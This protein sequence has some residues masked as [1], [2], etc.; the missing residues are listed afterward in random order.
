MVVTHI[1]VIITDMTLKEAHSKYLESTQFD[2]DPK[3]LEP[4][5]VINSKTGEIT[6]GAR[7]LSYQKFVERILEDDEF[8]QTFG[9]Q[10]EAYNNY[11]Q[12]YKFD[13][14]IGLCFLVKRTDGK[15]LYKKPDRE[16]FYLLIE[17]DSSFK[18]NWGRGYIKELSLIERYNYW[19]THNYET[20]IEYH[21]SLADTVDY[22]NSYYE[23]T[24]KRIII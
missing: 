18:E 20:G 16:T 11:S 19:Y 22:D 5:Q 21:E 9:L 17:S 10:S 15:T 1:N 3:W 4:V 7:Q 14:S 24:P 6:V 13:N 23:K 8:Y 2:S 12:E